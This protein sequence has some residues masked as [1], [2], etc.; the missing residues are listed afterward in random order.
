MN[1]FTDFI[2]DVSR[3]KDLQEAI[4][5]LSKISYNAVT[6]LEKCKSCGTCIKYC[7]LKIRKFNSENIAITMN[8]D[9]SCGGCS[10]CFHRCPNNAILLKPI[11]KHQG[12]NE[13]SY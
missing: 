9:K 4:N 3:S 7:P 5:E 6:I 13:F 11:N 8:S 12:K 10:V 1:L 2:M